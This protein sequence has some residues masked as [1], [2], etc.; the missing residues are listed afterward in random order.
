MLGA[1]GA[2]SR[3]L[4]GS[5]GLDPAGGF[6]FLELQG[7]SPLRTSSLPALPSRLCAQ[8][9]WLLSGLGFG[10]HWAAARPPSCEV[11]AAAPGEGV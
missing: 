7:H 8:P 9:T 11:A 5:P 6:C 4:L 10:G 2:L 3:P 1:W